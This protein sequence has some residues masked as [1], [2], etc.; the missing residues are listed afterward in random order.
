MNGELSLVNL[1]GD[2]EITSDIFEE[3]RKNIWNQEEFTKALENNPNMITLCN[4][5]HYFDHM[6]PDKGTREQRA[7][8]NLF[9]LL[10]LEFNNDQYSNSRIGWFIWF[11]VCYAKYDSYYPMRWATHYDP[12]N[13][14]RVGEPVREPGSYTLTPED[15]FN[16]KGRC[17]VHPEWYMCDIPKVGGE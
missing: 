3:T 14:Y 12:L 7:W 1:L 9:K 15:P 17:F 2:I 16:I 4:L 6:S 11:M 8:S 5:V 10:A 13:W